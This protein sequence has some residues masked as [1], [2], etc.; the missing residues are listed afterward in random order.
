M[1]QAPKHSELYPFRSRRLGQEVFLSTPWG[2]TAWLSSEDHEALLHEGALSTAGLAELQSNGFL[3]NSIS[4]EGIREAYASRYHFLKN[5]PTLHAMVL[6]ERCNHGCQYC[7]SSVVG[8][9]RTDTDMTVETAEK[10]VEFALQTT[11]PWLTIEFQG[12][13]LPRTGKSSSISSGTP[14]KRIPPLAERRSRSR[15]SPISA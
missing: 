1:T 5:G 15:W 6:T 10:S 9:N 14:G 12:E 2:S 3:K 7:H 8:M 11:S 13:S 4:A